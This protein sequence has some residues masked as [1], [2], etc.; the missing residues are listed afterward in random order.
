MMGNGMGSLLP[1][2]FV[3]GVGQQAS[4]PAPGASTHSARAWRAA[5]RSV[6]A[7]MAG[8]RGTRQN[9]TGEEDYRHRRGLRG[10]CFLLT[11][12]SPAAP[13]GLLRLAP[14]TRRLLQRRQLVGTG[15]A[16]GWEGF[17]R[18]PQVVTTAPG[19]QRSAACFQQH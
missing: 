16:K 17:T 18:G 2:S 6:H 8:A 7:G 10:P 9:C 19:H 3:G 5:A 15:G 12:N 1:P 4:L 13:E 11:A 14:D